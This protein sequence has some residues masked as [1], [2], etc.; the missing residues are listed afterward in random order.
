MKPL[1]HI[2]G[3]QVEPLERIR[4]KAKAMARILDLT[5]KA[6]DGKQNVR[7]AAIHAAAPA[8]ADALLEEINNQIDPVESLITELSPVVGTH[9]GPGTLGLAY[10]TDL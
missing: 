10:C 6:V 5:A 3:G 4:T 9:G 2:D 8:D 1:L 7:I